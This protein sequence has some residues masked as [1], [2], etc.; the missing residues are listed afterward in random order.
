MVYLL[1]TTVLIPMIFL[2]I[3]IRY[4]GKNNRELWKLILLMF[5]WGSIIAFGLSIILEGFA[6]FYIPNLLIL[7]V[8]FV[9]IIE[10]ISKAVGLRIVK[11]HITKLEDGIILGGFSGFGF[12]ATENLL[13][14]A[15][16]WNEGALTLLSLF[17]LRTIGRTLLHVSATALNG[18]GYSR[19]I[20]RYKKFR[21]ILLFITISIGIHALYNLLAIS[22]LLEVQILSVLISILFS[23]LLIF[24]IRKNIK[25]TDKKL[26][27]KKIASIKLH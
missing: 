25:L 1:L 15:I 12:V 11:N 7:L 9:P 3:W 19:K 4:T 14:G 5:I 27:L 13:Y 24:F 16:Y 21:T 22:D 20:I 10:E 17:Y 2:L 18:Y 6:F 8:I 26:A 23:L